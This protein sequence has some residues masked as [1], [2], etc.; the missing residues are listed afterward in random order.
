M[1]FNA[2]LVSL[3]ALAPSCFAQ[4]TQTQKTADFLQLAGLYAKN[5]AP[6]E[7]RRD[8]FGFDLYNT[9]PW[10]AEIAASTNDLTFY[11][12]CTRYIASLQDSHDEFI[13]PSDFEAVLGFDADIF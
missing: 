5:Y 7:L 3:L 2:I 8:L 11:D 6:Y 4:L 9:A 13:T 10:L 1:R 12:I